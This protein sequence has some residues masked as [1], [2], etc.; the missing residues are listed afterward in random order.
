MDRHY[1][2]PGAQEQPGL[3]VVQDQPDLE[4]TRQEHLLYGH[5]LPEVRGGEYLHSTK[6]A[7]TPAYAYS[8]NPEHYE[9][10]VSH[11]SHPPS[12]PAAG[13]G[14]RRLRLIIGGVIGVLVILGAV[15]GGVLGSRA[16]NSPSADLSESSG[17]SGDADNL[18]DNTAP[19]STPPVSTAPGSTPPDNTTNSTPIRQGS[20]LAVTG[21][22]KQDGSVETYL[23]FQ[24]QTDGLQYIRCDGSHRSS[25]KDSTCWALPVNVNSYAKPGSRLAASAIIWGTF[26]EVS[27]SPRAY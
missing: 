23:F 14:K 13:S 2:S 7:I 12:T 3:Q 9:L 27:F 15:L 22:R 24:D 10:P 19:G 1:Y 16:A 21:W 4:V 11:D 20:G 5:S 6:E 18:A 25:D 8:V 26:F 17:S